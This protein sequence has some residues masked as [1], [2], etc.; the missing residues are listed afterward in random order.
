MK[1][2]LQNVAEV[3]QLWLKEHLPKI[4]AETL[5]WLAA[6]VIHAA[7]IPTLYAGRNMMSAPP[8]MVD[9]K[10]RRPGSGGIDYGGDVTYFN[11]KAEVDAQKAADAAKT[12]FQT[13]RRT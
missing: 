3:M 10:K 1:F 13:P 9:G 6:I 12:G 5:G 2:E 7:T 8:T 4:S 11:T